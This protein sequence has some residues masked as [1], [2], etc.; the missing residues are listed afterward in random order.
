MTIAIVAQYSHNCK[1]LPYVLE[2]NR[3]SQQTLAKVGTVKH[4]ERKATVM[5]VQCHRVACQNLEE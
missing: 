3:L 1:Y 5:T 2:M 4:V